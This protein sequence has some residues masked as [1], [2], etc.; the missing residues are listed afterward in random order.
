MTVIDASLGFKAAT[1]WRVA[2]GADVRLVL[3]LDNFTAA[4]ACGWRFAECVVT[5]CPGGSA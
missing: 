3:A 1:L 2:R 4:G 5:R